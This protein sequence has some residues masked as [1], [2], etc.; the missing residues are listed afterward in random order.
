MQTALLNTKEAAEFLGVSCAFLERDRCY[1]GRIRFIKV[2][3]RAVRYRLED[4]NQFIQ[5]QTFSSTSH[6]AVSA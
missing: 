4:L 3:S 6:V 1:T 5:S 2:G